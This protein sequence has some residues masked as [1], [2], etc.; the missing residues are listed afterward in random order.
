MRKSIIAVAAALLLSGISP[1]SAFGY[2][3]EPRQPSCLSFGEPDD[4]C[5]RAVQSYLKDGESYIDCL[6]RKQDE[7]ID[8]MNAAVRKFNCKAS[9]QTFCP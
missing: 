8:Q 3:N 5:R 4:F 6:D 9:G 7:T 1:A 2:C